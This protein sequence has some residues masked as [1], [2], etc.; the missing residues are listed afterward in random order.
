MRARLGA[1]ALCAVLLCGCSMQEVSDRIPVS[2]AALDSRGDGLLLTAQTITISGDDTAPET[3]NQSIEAKSV[4]QGMDRCGQALFWTTAETA[5]L[6]EGLAKN[7]RTEQIQ[8]LTEE[9]SIRP[10]VRLCVARDTEGRD[11]LETEDRADGLATL[12]DNAVQEGRAVDMPLYQA[13]DDQQTD[14][15]DL[16]LP[17]LTVEQD[18]VRTAGTAVFHG[19]TLCG[20]LEEDETAVLALLR[21]DTHRMV[22]YDTDGS[23]FVLTGVHTVFSVSDEGAALSLRGKLLDSSEEQTQRAARL[24]QTTCRDL[25]QTL[26]EWNSDALGLGRELL[27]T[28]PES[29]STADWEAR[30]PTI[31]VSITVSLTRTQGGSRE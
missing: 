27:R 22:L 11:I 23:R 31:P 6:D 4:E 20:Y 3:E 26:Q 19:E 16:A 7:S 12:L 13:L 24:C 28:H 25:M 2:A 21:G 9:P 29:F 14:G 8:A 5:I 15:V 18:R 30:Y 10:S 17:A 1:A